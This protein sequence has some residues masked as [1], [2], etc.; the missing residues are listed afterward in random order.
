MCAVLA[1]R[2]AGES[3]DAI[4][5][6][7]RGGL[8]PAALLA[9]ELDTRDVLVAAVASYKGEERGEQLVFLEFPR[10]EV[11]DGRRLLVV[12]DIWDSGRTVEHTRRRVIEAGG[13]PVIVVL[14]YKPN[15][16]HYPSLAP[17]YWIGETDAWVVYPWERDT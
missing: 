15:Q 9:Q 17:D 2:L 7:A 8:I 1:K 4:L 11:I 3:F 6:I 10:D 12:D 14:H 13:E 16:S 5:G